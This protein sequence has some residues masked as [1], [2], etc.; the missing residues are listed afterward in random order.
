MVQPL[1]VP[2]GGE[3]DLFSAGLRFRSLGGDRIDLGRALVV[4]HP[5][6]D[7]AGSF[8]TGLRAAPGEVAAL[9]ARCAEHL[10]GGCRRVLV[11]ADTPPAVEA[12]LALEDWWLDTRVDLVLPP[13]LVPPAPTRPLHPVVGDADWARLA[14]LLRQCHLEVDARSGRRTRPEAAT[15]GSVALRRSM[16]PEAGWFAVEQG[17]EFVA[18]IGS[19][20]GDHGV[21][22]VADVYVRADVRRAGMAHDLLRFA[23][24]HVRAGGAGPV[25][26]IAD[27]RGTPKYLYNRFGFEPTALTRLWTRQA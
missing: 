20:P 10:P 23:V 19:W 22:V 6:D 12:H 17:G 5:A 18:M 7:L 3:I 11:D 13:S 26:A 24:G 8:A 21:G 9:L 15:A 2:P 16:T 1:A 27:T 25:L 14:T 4:R